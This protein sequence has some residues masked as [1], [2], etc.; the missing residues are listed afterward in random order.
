MSPGVRDERQTLATFAK[1]WLEHVKAAVRLRIFRRYRE[2][3]TLHALPVLGDVL[4]ARLTPSQAESL[5]ARELDSGLAPATVRQLHVVLHHVLQDALRKEILLRNVCDL[6]TV[7]RVP[8][9]EIRP[10]SQEEAGK[11]LQAA[12]GGR[13]EALYMLALTTGMRQGE[14][15]GM[16]WRDAD[17]DARTLSVRATLQNRA[18]KI[19]VAEPKTARGRRQ[20]PLLPEA[21]EARRA[22]RARK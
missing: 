22:H 18:G 11:R 20:A 6:V 4:L 17:L 3:L 12:A 5:H 9:H 2:L 7:P 21:V 15:L 19:L 10:L 1:S 8:R 14:L 16:R 13:L